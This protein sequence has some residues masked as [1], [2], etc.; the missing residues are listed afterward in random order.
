MNEL[1]HRLRARAPPSAAG[2]PATAHPVS[3]KDA[4]VLYFLELGKGLG[5]R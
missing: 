4:F 2:F 1:D 3:V 5:C